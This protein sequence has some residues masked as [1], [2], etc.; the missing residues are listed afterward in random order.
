MYFYFIYLFF[1]RGASLS[2]RFWFHWF[3]LCFF[4]FRNFLIISFNIFSFSLLSYICICVLFMPIYFE[5]SLHF[6]NSV[7]LLFKY[8]ISEFS[9]SNFYSILS[10]H[11]IWN[12]RCLFCY[13]VYL[14]CGPVLLEAFLEAVL[15]YTTPF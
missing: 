2:Y 10:N 14:F 15:F 1:E 11:I 12:M 4:F 13:N 6:W 3:G 9:N 7:F 8:P 5:F